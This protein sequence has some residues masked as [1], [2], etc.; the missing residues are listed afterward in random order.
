MSA[1]SNDNYVVGGERGEIL[2]PS[3]ED[4]VKSVS[5][6]CGRITIE[7]IEGLLNLNG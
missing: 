4:V 3:I 1:T 7:A 5:I 6:E 2:I